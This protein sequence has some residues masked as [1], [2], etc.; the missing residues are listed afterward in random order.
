MNKG[1]DVLKIAEPLYIIQTLTIPP[2]G[3]MSYVLL[4]QSNKGGMEH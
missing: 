3:V 4:K 1:S 2:P